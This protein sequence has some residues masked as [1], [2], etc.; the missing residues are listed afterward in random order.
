[1]RVMQNQIVLNNNIIKSQKV[2]NAAFIIIVRYFHAY[3]MF[4]TDLYRIIPLHSMLSTVNQR[5]V[6]DR[7]PVGIRKIVIA[8]SIA[9]TR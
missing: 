2:G 1:M 8:T 7:P 6:F 9:E 5:M 4:I 3:S